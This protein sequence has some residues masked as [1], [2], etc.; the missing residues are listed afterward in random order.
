MFARVFSGGLLGID[1]YRIEVEVDCTGGIGQIQ[2]VGLPDAAVKESQERVRSAIKACSFLVPPGK[3]W[4]VNLA[5]A[6]TKKE[7]PSF[8]LPIAVGILAATG[9]IPTSHLT[10]FWF[11]GELGLDGAV[12]PISGI[13]PIVLAGKEA[14]AVAIVVPDGNAEEASL[15]EEI[16][17]Y[18]VSHL[19]QVCDIIREPENGAPLKSEARKAFFTRQTHNSLELD[20]N[21]VKGQALAKRAFEIAAA[22]HHNI[23]LVG[24]P[25]SGK[26]MLAQRLPGIMPRLSFDE[27][28][29][30][31]KLYSVAGLL[32]NRK[33][34]LL[35]RP[36]R[37]PHHSAS[38]TGL[39]GGGSIPKPG[40][41]SL[42]HMGILFL[43]ELTEF[44]RAHL[45]TL[46]QPLETASVTIS[47]VHQTLT[48]PAS[49]LF[50]GACNPCPCGYRGDPIK[51]CVCT[52]SQADRYWARLSG[53]LLDRIDLHIDVARLNEIELAENGSGDSSEL[54]R[55]RVERAVAAQQD[56]FGS[57]RYIPNG[58]LSHRQVTGFCRIDEA[59]RMLL[60]RAVTQLGLSARAYDRVLRVART[61]ADLACQEKIEAIHIA[62]ALK[63]RGNVRAV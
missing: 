45:D 41:I 22:G 36:F 63:Y 30:L 9:L 40:E 56:R 46:R 3:K 62:E 44:P 52:P 27:A 61:I 14:G 8:D 59:S 4:V 10:E 24:P 11:V 26:S 43:D 34:L 48:Y 28:M 21:E 35:E 17:I 50:V 6:D 38:A 1:A 53:P 25:G 31:T 12:R 54:I 29:E 20:F 5:P 55:L 37:S 15:V 19:K 16:K 2:I 51:Y 13:L 33:A 47:R 32:S 23:L 57:G 49:F 58:Q 7:G 39:I 42:S 18:P 60:A